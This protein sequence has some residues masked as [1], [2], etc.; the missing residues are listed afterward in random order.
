MQILS[1]VVN[2]NDMSPAVLDFGSQQK[3]ADGPGPKDDT[4]PGKK[5]N[6]E[7]HYTLLH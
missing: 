5:V 7:M 1:V 6:V 4:K 3:A 2:N